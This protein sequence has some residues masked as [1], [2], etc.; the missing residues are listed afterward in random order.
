MIY[1]RPSSGVN[2]AKKGDVKAQKQQA[3]KDAAA[4]ALAESRVMLCRNCAR[5]FEREKC[6]RKHEQVCH[7]QLASC[8]KKRKTAVLRPAADLAQDQVHSAA[9]L[10]IGQGNVFRGQENKEMFFPKTIK[11]FPAPPDVPVVQEGWA[12]TG[13]TGVKGGVFKT[14]QRDFLLSL[15]NNNGG[16]KIRERDTHIRM[17]NT[18]KD[19]DED[20]DYSLRLV[21]SESQIK[22]WFSSETGCRKKAAVNRVG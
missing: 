20:S 3:V 17:A 5:P 9:S 4:R 8:E 22:S 12:C 18:F 6:L 11:F 2:G 21:L 19:K 7:E 16:P 15:F 10:S 13:V 1:N 14:S